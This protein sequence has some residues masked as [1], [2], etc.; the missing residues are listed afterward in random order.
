M[1]RTEE[2]W[3]D[4]GVV[5]RTAIHLAT[6]VPE[7]DRLWNDTAD[8]L[9]EAITAVLEH[10]NVPAGLRAG[11]IEDES[12]LWSRGGEIDEDSDSRPAP[13]ITLNHDKPS[14]MKLL[15]HHC[16]AVRL[17]T[18]AGTALRSEDL[19]SNGC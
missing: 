7:L 2:L 13:P 8:I 6:A 16:R 10:L 14:E 5:M 9:I 4:H 1:L 12:K 19:A 18:S 3:R 17:P 11:L 15:R